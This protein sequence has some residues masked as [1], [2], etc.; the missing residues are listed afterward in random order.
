MTTTQTAISARSKWSCWTRPTAWLLGLAFWTAA[1]APRAEAEVSLASV[2]TD[3]MVLQQDR[4][5][6]VWGQAAPGSKITVSIQD[7][8]AEAVADANGAF[9]AVL[10]PLKAGG[11]FTLTVEGDGALERHDVL[12]G[13]VWICSGQ[14]N[15]QWSFKMLG[16]AET[17]ARSSNPRIRLL[18]VP[19]R[20]AAT[21]QTSFEGR[22][23]ACGPE[24]LG[25]FSAVAYY[26]G[27]MLEK[28]LQVP[29][30]LIST[31]YGGTPAEAWT[32]PETLA[33][34][35]ELAYFAKNLDK[36]LADLEAA[37][38]S[39]RNEPGVLYN[40]M[41]APLVPYAIRG[42]I[43]YQGESNAGRAYE[44][45][46][47][48]PAMI[49]D[50]RAAWGQGDFPFLFVQLA[51]FKKIVESP[52]ESDWAELR[53]AQAL[54]AKIVPQTAMAVIT[55]AGDPNDIHPK[56]K[57]P[58]GERLAKAALGMTYGF[59][60][61]YTGPIYHSL[62][63]KGN[64]AIVKFVGFAGGLVARDGPLTG[65]AVA[66][67]DGVFVNAQARIEG[68]SVIATAPEVAHPVAVRFGWADYPV[69]NLFDEAGLP[70]SP[71]RTDQAP[72]VTRKPR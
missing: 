44:Y 16:D 36:R 72:G 15:M 22:W 10:P 3:G 25:D 42:V 4:P 48:F 7:Q 27:R 9:R 18:T 17:P 30:G 60:T 62:T 37:G 28:E 41:I 61:P 68:D 32:R 5:V 31:N 33:S 1:V 29:I 24:T 64:E 11:P 70:A 23:V 66:G 47:L 19:R 20:G 35:P 43:W 46:T 50:W 52:Q 57:Q 26:F 63:I 69:V 21:P 34:Y 38:K 49:H 13:E 39:L 14:S 59:D 65:F 45:R 8:T 12:V 53:E 56:K 67:P 40:A 2:F 54:T 55:D 58:V 6:P 51:P 71:F